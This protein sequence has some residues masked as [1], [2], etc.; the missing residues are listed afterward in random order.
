MSIE[1]EAFLQ[2]KMILCVSSSTVEKSF[3]FEALIVRF[4]SEIKLSQALY[5]VTRSSHTEKIELSCIK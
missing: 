2:E 3:P 1:L 5:T 4:Y